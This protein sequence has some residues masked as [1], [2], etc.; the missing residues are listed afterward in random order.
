M[1]VAVIVPTYQMRRSLEDLLKSFLKQTQK[2]FKI[3][4]VDN[5]PEIEA[6]QYVQNILKEFHD[7]DIS[8]LSSGEN[9]GAGGGR[10]FGALSSEVK[11]CE[12]FAFID[13][14]CEAHSEWIQ[15]IERRFT[16]FVE[17]QVIFGRVTSDVL[18]RPPFI[19]G[20]DMQG[21]VFGSGNC[22]IRKDF[23]M[24]MGGFDTYLNNWAED[25]EI[26]E[27]CKSFNTKPVYLEEMLVNHPPKLI[28]YEF[29]KYI[30]NINFY[31]KFIYIIKIRNYDYKSSFRRD[32]FKRALIR[33]FVFFPLFALSYIHPF[34]IFSPFF[35]N[36]LLLGRK[37]PGLMKDIKS[38]PFEDK[39]S[40]SGLMKYLLF[41]WVIDI[42]NGGLLMVY[43]SPLIEKVLIDQVE[44]ELREKGISLGQHPNFLK[45]S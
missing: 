15:V 17:D 29:S 25:F 26:G 12:I 34:L 6:N 11:N 38:Y 8:Y 45:P 14:D 27:R 42:F 10:N 4:I 3:I 39:L 40:I 9:L 37:L 21:G 5:N 41:G 1:T 35:F 19:H 20:F 2:N 30:L 13:D 33:L 24:R 16:S 23:F 18:P 44:R 43:S 36:F 28:N 31:K 7:L 32:L 22:A